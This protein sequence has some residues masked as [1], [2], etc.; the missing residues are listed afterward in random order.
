MLKEDKSI[1]IFLQNNNYYSDV[2]VTPIFACTFDTPEFKKLDALPEGA[3]LI[4]IVQ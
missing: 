3:E 1:S 2:F 4:E